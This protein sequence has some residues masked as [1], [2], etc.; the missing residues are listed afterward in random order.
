METFALFYFYHYDFFFSSPVSFGGIKRKANCM[1][2]GHPTLHEWSLS[3]IREKSLPG[4]PVTSR[5][6]FTLK[7]TYRCAFHAYESQR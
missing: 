7:Y 2:P 6:F 3:A 1:A 5:F 4:D